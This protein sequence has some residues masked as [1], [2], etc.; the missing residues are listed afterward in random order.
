MV[1]AWFDRYL[2]DLPSRVERWPDVQIQGSDGQ[3]WEL[4]E[5]PT[6]GG[7]VG[8]LALG[9]EGTLGVSQ[10][11]GETA[12][13][14]QLHIGPPLPGQEAAFQTESLEAPLHITGQPVLDLWLTTSRPDGHVAAALEVVDKEGNVTRHEGS[15]S[16]DVAS[17]GV[18]SLQ[19]LQPMTRGWFEQDQGEPATTGEPIHA[20]VRFLPTDLVVP[21][22]SSLRVRILGSV[23]YSKGESQPSGA[24]STITL[25][26]DCRHPSA[27]RF[28]MPDPDSSL[29]NVRE[30]DERELEKLSSRPQRI[31]S[32]DGGGIATGDVCGRAPRAVSLLRNGTE[33]R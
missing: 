16:E 26:H 13:S 3:W 8:Q 33:R 24:A 15:R 25:L 5:Y 32:G 27:L 18:R 23:A 12:Y 31:G 28:A 9:P 7:P 19:H 21:R 14:E 22:G 17:Y 6:T 1:T 29:L 10:P 20:V 11:E 4:E 2:K 30:E